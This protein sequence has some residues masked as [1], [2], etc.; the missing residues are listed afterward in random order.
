MFTWGSKTTHNFNQ[1]VSKPMQV[2]NHARYL[3]VVMLP[4]VHI[5]LYRL[6]S[7]RRDNCLVNHKNT[8]FA[9]MSVN[10]AQAVRTVGLMQGRHLSDVSKSNWCRLG[11]GPAALAARVH[12]LYIT[13][14]ALYV[15][16]PRGCIV[17][18]IVYGCGVMLFSINKLKL[19]LWYLRQCLWI[20]WLYS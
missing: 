17:F 4:I 3:V 9:R 18:C 12:A 20:I 16:Y 6:H 1:G 15:W 5:Y 11:I 8:C 7:T 14:T 2:L 10:I 19:K 13:C